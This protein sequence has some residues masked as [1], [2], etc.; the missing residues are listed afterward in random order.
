MISTIWAFETHHHS[1]Q[2]RPNFGVQASGLR[3]QSVV[4]WVEHKARWK[5][6][7][8]GVLLLW[9][10][11][12]ASG[13]ATWRIF[14]FSAINLN[15]SIEDSSYS[16]YPFKTVDIEI[17]QWIRHPRCTKDQRLTP[18]RL[19]AGWFLVTSGSCKQPL[20]SSSK[21]HSLLP[22]Y[23]F[24]YNFSWVRKSSCNISWKVLCVDNDW[25]DCGGRSVLLVAFAHFP[26]IHIIDYV[27]C[28]LDSSLLGGLRAILHTVQS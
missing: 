20:Q 21:D 2:M 28:K 23:H 8:K 18:E 15:S 11:E 26:F 17:L 24:H 13:P 10:P 5:K 12:R 3:I 19:L 6:G 14:S 1:H 9:I 27:S 7:T 25:V 22:P 4:W 16:S